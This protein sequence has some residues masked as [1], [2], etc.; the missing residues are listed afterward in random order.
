MEPSTMEAWC[1]ATQMA[2]I[3]RPAL[4]LIHSRVL[5][6]DPAPRVLSFFTERWGNNPGPTLLG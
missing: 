5:G 6:K 1:G 4:L 2:E 3:P